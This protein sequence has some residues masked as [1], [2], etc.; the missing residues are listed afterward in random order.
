[1]KKMKKTKKKVKREKKKKEKC[2]KNV[3]SKQAKVS[4][5]KAIVPNTHTQCICNYISI[6]KET[7]SITSQSIHPRDSLRWKTESSLPRLPSFR[8]L[9]S[10]ERQPKSRFPRFPNFAKFPKPSGQL[11]TLPNS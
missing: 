1:M 11:V 7:I 9:D 10:K 5:S 6:L 3:A 8:V 4:K 2:S